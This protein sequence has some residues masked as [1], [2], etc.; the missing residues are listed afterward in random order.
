MTVKFLSRSNRRELPM[1]LFVREHSQSLYISRIH[2][3]FQIPHHLDKVPCYNGIKFDAIVYPTTGTDLRRLSTPGEHIE[4]DVPLS[5]A[6]RKRCIQDLV[7]GLVDLHDLGIVHGGNRAVYALRRHS[8]LTLPLTDIHPGNLTLPPPSSAEIEDYLIRIPPRVDEVRRKDG[9]PTKP[10]LPTCVTEPIDLGFGEGVAR[11]ID[12]GFAFRP[13]Q[14]GQYG[15]D[16]FPTGTPL[17][18]E[19]LDKGATT[20]LPFKVDSWHLGLCVRFGEPA[21]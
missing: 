7:R 19:L 4:G 20:V 11:I 18:P 15:Q 17:P 3:H 21:R 16:C 10:T 13:N 12:L 14:G 9:S 1:A 6:R 2:D 8:R 5:L